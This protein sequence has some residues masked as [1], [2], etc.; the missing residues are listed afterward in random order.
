MK[1]TPK[2]AIHYS[3]LLLLL[4]LQIGAQENAGTPVYPSGAPVVKIFANV[5][6]GL[7]D[8]DQSRAFEIRRAYIGY[9][10]EF[11]PHFATELKLDIGSPDDVSEFSRIRRYAY[12]KAVALYW[13]KNQWTLK[14]GIIDTEHFKDQEKYWKH[15]YIYE[16]VQD[17]H[18]FG[19]SADLGTTVIYRPL[20]QLQLDASLLNGEGY[21][22][23]Q[24]DNSFKG[25]FGISY[26]P[27]PR[28]L[29]RF[30]GDLIRQ[31]V[32][33]STL[34]A[35]AGYS[36]A[37]ITAGAEYNRKGNRDFEEGHNQMA[38]SFYLSYDITEKLEIFARY[39][40]LS[41]NI[42]PE[43]SKPWNL[44]D[45]GS[46]LIGGIQY[47]P[48]RHIRIALNYQ[49]WFPYA[50]NMANTSY[51]FLNLEVVL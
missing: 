3:L 25:S 49:D 4:P 48:I 36:H 8:A 44:H 1:C 43:E 38:L 11:D 6:T 18:G 22:N 23:L 50:A 26:F 32:W 17:E 35:F 15:R 10:Y 7:T 33:Q 24:R 20:D 16:S 5:H 51:L 19:P 37:K 29:L 41:S 39:D 34:S 31:E 2:L 27:L 28:I 46:A 9:K 47:Q 40:R 13:R 21:R 14:A 45:D 12:F 30:Y 42:P